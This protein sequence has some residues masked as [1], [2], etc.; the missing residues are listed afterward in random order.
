MGGYAILADVVI[1]QYALKR[2]LFHHSSLCRF[3]HFSCTT[4][5][6]A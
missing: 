5:G 1:D 3:G 6:T 4:N 2:A